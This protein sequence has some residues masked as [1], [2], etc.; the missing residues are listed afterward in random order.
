MINKI[1]I[2]NELAAI[3]ITNAEKIQNGVDFITS[4]TDDFQ[5]G[6]M[7]RAKGYEVKGHYHKP[8][9][10]EIKSTSEVLIIK[11]GV[12]DC[13]IFDPNNVNDNKNIILKKGDLILKI[14]FAHSFKF[15]EETEMI[16][17]KQGPFIENKISNI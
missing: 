15:L 11:K 16:E 5:L 17:V 12:V 3:V 10:R 7:K 13:N 1:F 9:I 4:P 2:K 6:L 8:M 14:K